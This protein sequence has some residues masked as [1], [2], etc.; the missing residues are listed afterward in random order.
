MTLLTLLPCG[1]RPK[2]RRGA[3]SCPRPTSTSSLRKWNTP[4]KVPS[5]ALVGRFRLPFPVLGLALLAAQI[6]FL[7]L[8]TEVTS[9]PA[10]PPDPRFGVVEAYRAPDLATQAGVAWERF[11]FY[12]HVIQPRSADDWNSG[13]LHDGVLQNELDSGRSVVGLLISTPPWASDGGRRTDPPRNLYLP[14]DHPDNAWGRFVYRIVSQYRGRIDT[15]VIWNEPDVWDQNS[16]GFTWGGSEADFYQLMKVAYQSAKAADPEAKI[17]LPGLTYWWDQT[18]GREQYLTRLLR[19]ASQDPT[20]P[21][22]GW[23]F[24]GVVL[25][26][27]NDPANLRDIPLEYRRRLAEFG[28][29]KPIWINETNV[30]PWDDPTHPLSADWF[31]ATQDEQASFI[32][33]AFAYALTAG[34]ERISVYKMLDDP[35][36]PVEAEPFGLVR[37]DGTPRP[38][39]TALQVATRHFAGVTSGEVYRQGDVV[40]IV[41]HRKGERISVVWNQSPQPA[42]ASIAAI[43]DEAILVSKSG[44]SRAVVPDRGIYRLPLEP[45]TYHTI[46]G[47]P[48]AYAI[49]GSPLILVE[50]IDGAEPIDVAGQIPVSTTSSC[51]GCD[52]AH[53][54][55]F[56]I[57]GHTVSGQWLDFFE[58]AGLDV[59]GYPRSEVIVDPLT[60]QWAQYFQRVVLEWHAVNPTAHRIQR[61]LLADDVYP[62]ADAPLE[63][64][65]PSSRRYAFFPASPDQPTGLGHGVSDY[66][67][68]GTYIGFKA[69]F[70]AHGGVM[71]FGYPKEEPV[72][73]EGRWTQRFQ[74]AVFEYHPEN[75]APYRVQLELLGDKLIEQ[76]HLQL[77]GERY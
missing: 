12:W 37:A 14:Y 66:A 72:L 71:T 50:R 32:I 4:A 5:H 53:S 21:A 73:R 31:R 54:R 35:D 8:P 33:Q 60:G 42:E 59:M 58:R 46:P 76:K 68:D 77:E 61:R 52:P 62:G 10:A 6:A 57:T 40:R 25:Q 43:A 15:W 28:L 26:L 45:A 34:V 63:P 13:Y 69:F 24:D 7:L 3:T 74:A 64:G 11:I 19:L 36:L 1:T 65:P 27:Y 47:L 18:A 44:D 55:Y 41:L 20:A 29:D 2:G 30:A 22:N 75:A 38:A 9:A 16:P 39:Y 51:P 17:L 67:P 56:A 48:D 49:G 70:D 23:Y